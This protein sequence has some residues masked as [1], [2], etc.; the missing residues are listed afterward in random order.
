[1]KS[2]KISVILDIFQICFRLHLNFENELFKKEIEIS[3]ESQ[4]AIT[5]DFS[6][7]ILNGM[8]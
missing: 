3:F 5:L 7:N 4:N 6:L 1:M 8:L 2:I